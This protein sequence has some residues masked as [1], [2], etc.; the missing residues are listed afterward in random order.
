M[1]GER[2]NPQRKR[3]RRAGQSCSGRHRVTSGGTILGDAQWR[4]RFM[5]RSSRLNMVSKS[6]LHFLVRAAVA[7][8]IVTVTTFAAGAEADS[9]RVTFTPQ[10]S[11]ALLA[12]PHMGWETF[13]RPAKTDKTLPAW[14]PS[15]V[16]YYR[17]RWNQLETRR[18]EIDLQVLEN[19]LAEAAAS[20]Q[21]LAIRIMSVGSSARQPYHPDWL[22]SIPGALRDTTHDGGA[23]QVPDLDNPV[24]LESQLRMIREI[25]RR[26]DGDP[27]LEHVDIGQVGFWGEWHMSGQKPVLHVPMPK[28]ET[29]RQIVDAYFQAFTRT[30]LLMLIGGRDYL[31]YAATKGAGWRADCFGD[32]GGVR[33]E[34]GHMRNSYP[35]RFS[36]A[37]L[38]D[39]WQH[40][41]IAYET[42]WDM[43][44]WVTLGWDLRYIFNYGL[45]THAS[46]LNNKSAR[47][48]EG[49]NVR[50]ELERFLKR[51]GYRL[52]LRDASIEG[53]RSELK[54]RSTWQNI[55][56]APCYRPYKVAWRLR[57]P[58]VDQ[59]LRTDTTV[60]RW[61]PGEVE[62]FT[63][64]FLGRVPDLPP[65]PRQTI[66]Q[67]LPVHV[68]AGT[69][70]LLV[71]IVDDQAKPV[72]Q[73]AIEGRQADGW[74][75]LGNYTVK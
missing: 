66:E 15:T 59:V 37:N 38:H 41:P 57:G 17:I 8:A 43:R 27:R 1:P 60:S 55:G 12:N 48:P 35:D 19:L 72:V 70:E 71:G 61:M 65:G 16:E 10:E 75:R 24:V 20:G 4:A 50:P 23:L 9:G 18:G 21:T 26:F 45:A 28:P 32:L 25:G 42:C 30:P 67:T 44:K 22:R 5:S 34:W 36:Q 73:L 3:P 63:V 56:S 54:L 49:E 11:D 39:V 13:Q 64:D 7:A 58:G 6:S 51:L 29:C 40:A 52:V 31:K 14:I 68:P 2:G 69:Y 74:Y 46:F 62:V 47:L 33:P 53:N